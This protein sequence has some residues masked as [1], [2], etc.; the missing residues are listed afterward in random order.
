V[1]VKANGV[2]REA[3]VGALTPVVTEI[4]DVREV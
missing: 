2:S 3:L 1:L 4:E